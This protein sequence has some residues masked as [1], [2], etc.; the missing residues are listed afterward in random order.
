MKTRFSKTQI[1][2]GLWLTLCVLLLASL[3]TRAETVIWS[4]DFDDGLGDNRWAAD[5]G[6]WQIGSPTVGPATNLLGARTFSGTNCATTGLTGN[7]GA[8]QNTRLFRIASFTVPATNQSPRLRF[9]HWYSFAS[10]DSA[11]VEVKPVGSGTWTTISASYSGTGSGVWTRP[12]LDLTAYAGQTIQVAF[13]FNSE[14]FNEST[15]WYVDDVALVTGT[16]VF[17]NPDG[18]EL[19][20]GDWSADRGVWQVGVP[21]SGPGSA[22]AGTNCAATVLSGNYSLNLD[23]RF[24]SPPFT[25][26]TAAVSPAVRFRHW[27]SL[28]SGDQAQLAIKPVAS[29]SWTTLATYSGSS[30]GWI[31]PFIDLSAYA[32]QAVQLSFRLTSDGFNESSGWY[33]DEVNLLNYSSPPNITQAPTNQIVGIESPVMFVVGASG[34][35]PLSYQWW[36]N[37]N[38]ISGATSSTYLISSAQLTNTGDYSVVVSNAGGSVSSPLASLTVRP[39]PDAFTGTDVG[40]VGQAGNVTYSNGV[41]MIGG[42][43]EDIEETADA[44]Y[45]VYEPLDGDCQIIARIRNLQGSGSAREAGVMI[46]EG[47]GSGT[48]F[49]FLRVN[50]STNV[51]FRRRLAADAYTVDTGFIGRIIRGSA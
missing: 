39:L 43:G 44:F 12:S 27:H 48:K 22:Y 26:P 9:W 13:H 50:T 38:A 10:G 23:S 19:G 16:P 18:F 14:G 45:F 47:L 32:T 4:D 42:S 37:G 40:D 41:F 3:G 29:N 17:N 28:A 15:G 46:R 6:Q 31:F 5:A 11:V 51:V 7:Y 8:N 33:L 20:L 34:I 30:G 49:A 35:A 2:P 25:L 1:N 24:I 36:F 21:T